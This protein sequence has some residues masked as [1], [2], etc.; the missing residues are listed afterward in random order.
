MATYKTY[1]TQQM[2]D[3]NSTQSPSYGPLAVVC[4]RYGIGRT[5]AF[6]LAK[7]GF[8]ETF[9][10]C[11]KRYVYIRSLETL[12]ERMAKIEKDK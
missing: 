11:G 9:S 10:M 6:Q 7:D 5:K 1:G 8:L 2:K 12:P 4:E 3:E